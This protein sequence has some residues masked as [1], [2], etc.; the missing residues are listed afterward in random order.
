LG[1]W[2]G[3]AIVERVRM[4]DRVIRR[5]S[6]FQDEG[7]TADDDIA[8]SSFAAQIGSHGNYALERKMAVSDSADSRRNWRHNRTFT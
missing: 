8:A 4:A 7:R 6:G 2:Q 3:L 5:G 1:D